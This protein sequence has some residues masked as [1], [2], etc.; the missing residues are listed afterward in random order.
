MRFFQILNELK[1]KISNKK[2]KKEKKKEET[3]SLMTVGIIQ[4]KEKKRKKE[5]TLGSLL[6]L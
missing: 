6:W 3:N 4:P 2:E 1:G 5:I